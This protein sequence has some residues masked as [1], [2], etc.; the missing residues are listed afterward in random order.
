M[1]K[2]STLIFTCT[3]WIHPDTVIF[4]FF[5]SRFFCLFYNWFNLDLYL[6]LSLLYGTQVY[7]FALIPAICQLCFYCSGVCMSRLRS[8]GF[9]GCESLYLIASFGLNDLSLREKLFHR[10]SYIFIFL[11]CDF[12]FLLFSQV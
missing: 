10:L 2:R 12:Q 8:C 7:S 1:T 11:F 9:I 3:F 5:S 6:F 4:A